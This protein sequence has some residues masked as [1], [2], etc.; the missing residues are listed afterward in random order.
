[1][2]GASSFDEFMNITSKNFL[3]EDKNN[4]SS[5]EPLPENQSEIDDG[6]DGK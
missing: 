5:K 6:A 1:M 2:L 3:D 4:K